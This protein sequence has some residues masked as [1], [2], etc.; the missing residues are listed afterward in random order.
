MTRQ[1]LKTHPFFL[2]FFLLML[3]NPFCVFSSKATEIERLNQR[4]LY[5]FNE[6]IDLKDRMD[7]QNRQIN[8]VRNQTG[9]N[10]TEALNQLEQRIEKIEKN[11][12]DSIFLAE[13]QQLRKELK[14]LK[15]I[16]LESGAT[17][18]DTSMLNLT[19]ILLSVALIAF[20][21]FVFLF[22]KKRAAPEDINQFSAD[23]G[24][25][26]ENSN[27]SSQLNQATGTANE[28]PVTKQEAQQTQQALRPNI[29][30]E[31]KLELLY[32]EA[33]LLILRIKDTKTPED[34]KTILEKNFN[35]IFNKI[36]ELKEQ[37]GI[38]S[39]KRNR[40]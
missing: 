1:E 3:L 15:N 22:N 36:V 35:E 33:E 39:E 8:I 14:N 6:M 5:L 18:R 9:N 40:E 11:P 24:M 12:A 38:K 29:S 4:Y 21:G 27:H 16:T 32:K 26:A 19:F 20:S 10:N 2:Y 37:T 7:E 23:P 17:Q 34:K 30:F 31:I 25:G 28:E 13:I